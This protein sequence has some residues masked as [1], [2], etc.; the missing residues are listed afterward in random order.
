MT[1]ETQALPGFQRTY[2][3]A[4]AHD[5]KPTVQVGHDGITTA[6]LDRVRAELLAHELIKVRL[7]R[8]PDKKALAQQLASEAGAE[9]CGLIGHTVILYRAHPEKPKIRLPQREA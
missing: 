8:P 1:N 6:V 4:L 9:L 2:L 3:R 5:L 7:S